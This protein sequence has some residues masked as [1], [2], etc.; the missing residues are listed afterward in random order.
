M[1]EYGIAV[2]DLHSG[3]TKTLMGPVIR[4]VRRSQRRP[5][6]L[7]HDGDPIEIVDVTLDVDF[8]HVKETAEGWVDAVVDDEAVTI[9]GRHVDVLAGPV[10]IGSFH[11]DDSGRATLTTNSRAR[12]ERILA[13]WK[14]DHEPLVVVEQREHPIES[15]P[16][17]PEMLVDMSH[18]DAQSAEAAEE[19]FRATVAL[20]WLDDAIPALGGMT[21]REAAVAGRTA[22][23]RALL[24]EMLGEDA[25]AHIRL[26]L[27]MQP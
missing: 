1:E 25:L 24:P 19:E 20:N 23:L 6:L 11:C 14:E 26:E 18:R 15:D 3:R 7:N 27:G 8:A 10:T 5:N 17:G 16:D 9:L 13:R 21:P 4:A 22:E 2:E 12:F